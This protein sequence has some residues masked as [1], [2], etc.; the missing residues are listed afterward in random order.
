MTRKIQ[1]RQKLLI[2]LFMLLMPL[3]LSLPVYQ[4]GVHY[5][6]QREVNQSYRTIT[7]SFDEARV[8]SARAE[9][10]SQ[11]ARNYGIDEPAAAFL[12]MELV[13]LEQGGSRE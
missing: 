3:V 6:L 13:A 12:E 8:R 5:R 4:A 11:L 2:A 1:A 7:E 10:G 9:Q